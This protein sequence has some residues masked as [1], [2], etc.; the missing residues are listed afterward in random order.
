MQLHQPA[1]NP[2]NITCAASLA[3]SIAVSVGQSTRLTAM[4]HIIRLHQQFGGSFAPWQDMQLCRGVMIELVLRSTS[5]LSVIN[6][7]L[8]S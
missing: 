2:V 8:A 1:D 3:E 5:H 6:R 4:Q 7:Y